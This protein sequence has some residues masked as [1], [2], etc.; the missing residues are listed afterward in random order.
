VATLQPW[1]EISERLRR[2]LFITAIWAEISQPLRRTCSFLRSGLKLANAFGV[3]TETSQNQRIRVVPCSLPYRPRDSVSKPCLRHVLQPAD[4]V[5]RR[6]GRHRARCGHASQ[7]L[8]SPASSPLHRQLLRL[9]S[10]C[11]PRS[12]MWLSAAA[13]FAPPLR[14]TLPHVPD[15]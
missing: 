6:S 3:F 12:A 8:A 9:A 10:R 11:Y 14:A 7:A 13:R 2:I 4:R 1:A 5:A 15:L